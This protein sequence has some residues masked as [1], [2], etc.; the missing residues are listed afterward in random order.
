MEILCAEVYA[1]YLKIEVTIT[2]PTLDANLYL[3]EVTM[4][5]A[6]GPNS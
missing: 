5:A 6:T 2:D 3:E 4:T 1:R